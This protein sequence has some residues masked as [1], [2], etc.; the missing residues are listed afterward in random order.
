MA[1]S[2]PRRVEKHVVTASLDP[3]TSGDGLLIVLPVVAGEDWHWRRVREGALGSWHG[4]RPGDDAPWG[5][6][7]EGDRVVALV[8][9]DQAPVRI[10]LRG[11]MPQ[12]QALVAARLE[13]A[14]DGAGLHVAVAATPDG[15]A[16]LVATAA[17]AAM[18]LWLG[19]LAAAELAPDG[20][21]P[22]ALVLPAPASGTITGEL[23]G[24]PLARTPEAAFAGEPELVAALAGVTPQTVTDDALEA[25][26]LAAWRDPPLNLRQ[27]VYAP[28][29]VSFFR[30][31]DWFQ[32]ARMAAVAALL[33]FL[34]LAVETIKLNLDATA[35]EQ[36]ALGKAQQRFPAA[37]DLATAQT[38]A[39]AELVR[40]GEGGG[41][42]TAPTAALLAAMRPIPTLALRDLGY[43]PDGTLRFQAAAPTA[44]AINRLLTTLQQEGWQVTVPPSLAADA[45]G[46]TVAAITVRAP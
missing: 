14:Q 31:P 13:A 41:S 34:I 9:S 15:A 27:G 12:A 20:L 7:D 25:A 21:I 30:L 4:Y 46:A 28:R 23:A 3:P 18:D 29:R 8:P 16:V 10:R 19:G 36:A 35:R 38:L 37:V 32:L 26:L 43:A 44:D 42:F 17:T 1:I 22:A 45:T 33:G 24:Q 6:P 2:T 39:A 11:T 40:R 5:D